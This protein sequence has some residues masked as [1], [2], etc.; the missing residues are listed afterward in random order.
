MSDKL[1]PGFTVVP[2]F[3]EGETPSAAKLNS[4]PAQMKNAATAL[5]KAVGDIHDV[6]W[7]YSTLHNERLSLG[8]G[9]RKAGGDTLTGIQTRELLIANLARLVGPAANLNPK[10]LGARSLTE[11]I[12]VG[13]HEF[14]VQFP[15]SGGAGSETYSGVG[16]E[17]TTLQAQPSDVTSSGDYYVT[18]DGRFYTYDSTTGGTVT[19]PIDPSEWGGGTNHQGAR[20]N[21]YPDPAQL[22]AGDGGCVVVGP[23]GS[24]RYTVSLPTVIRQQANLDSSD[25]LLD[26]TD[27][28]YEVQLTLPLVLTE[29][30]SSEEEIPGGF[31]FLKNFTTNEVY[32]S[33][34][35]FYSDP[36]TI[37]I[38][39][40]DLDDALTA[41]DEFILFTVG[42]DLTTAVDDLRNK[43]RHNHDRSWG[44]PFV[45]YAGLEGHLAH[46]SGK[47]FYV[48][49]DL[50][51]NFAPQYLHRDGFTG[52][53]VDGGANDRNAMRGNI[54]FGIVGRGP[55]GYVDTSS[56][57]E[58]YG[59]YFGAS[60][61]AYDAHIYRRD[62][63]LFSIS[64]SQ[65]MELVSGG[66]ATWTVGG[67]LAWTVGETVNLTVTQSWTG[68][69]GS[70][71]WKVNQNLAG[72]SNATITVDQSTSGS[73]GYCRIAAENGVSLILDTSTAANPDSD[74][75]LYVRGSKS[76][77]ILY[78][79]NQS[80]SSF[81]GG[82]KIDLPNL[83]AV[84]GVGNDFL[85]FHASGE[86]LGSIRGGGT[87]ATT[88]VFFAQN[89]ATYEYAQRV[90]LPSQAVFRQK[91]GGV[92]YVSGSS[93]FGEWI[94]AGDHS[95]W[96]DY[97]AET[98]SVV[99]RLGISEGVVVYVRNQ[100]FWRTPGGT[101][102][103]VT[104]RALSVGNVPGTNEEAGEIL[105]FVGQVP[106]FAVG[107]VAEGDYLVPAE[108]EPNACVGINPDEI[109]FSDYKKA[110]GIAWSGKE[111]G[112]GL[113]LCA[114]GKK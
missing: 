98:G 58:T 35:Y 108:K 55:G 12:P 97:V 60:G 86:E 53:T 83:V 9:R 36:S 18:D 15:I 94:E 52:V 14:S 71:L 106:V 37:L 31:I 45:H 42:T 48:P 104:H 50:D 75:Q 49:S 5:E 110:I 69:Y 33:A 8:W 88:A 25:T 68:N 95:E 111:E 79:E 67:A 91:D 24:G 76:S 7:P 32:E 23:D 40:V 2:E 112:L 26:D 105:S 10:M 29:F 72:N 13:V 78:L 59:L 90:S 100:K 82:M 1:A 114:V 80:T 70:L 30:Y 62:A 44:E 87:G 54:L 84:A 64:S 81:A 63:G 102:M 73:D 47:G 46:E 51:G 85:E 21:T 89:G 17:F 38:S 34:S 19:Y 27:V 41:V 39:G 103:V 65:A 92:Q 77:Y 11:I 109:S 4:V 96:R 99:K 56:G 57:D 43:L 20:F 74:G 61:G 93:D 22:V 16:S 107:S 3:V 6:S 28:N 113:V 101:P 66:D